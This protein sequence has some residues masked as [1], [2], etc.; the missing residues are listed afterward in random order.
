MEASRS[1]S[2]MS[3]SKALVQ[4]ILRSQDTHDHLVHL[5]DCMIMTTYSNVF[6]SLAFKAK[7][8]CRLNM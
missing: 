1:G 6:V 5:F 2:S 3:E 7:S 4:N 8:E